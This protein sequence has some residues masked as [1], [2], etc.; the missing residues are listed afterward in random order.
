LRLVFFC[1]YP[2]QTGYISVQN[3][4]IIKKNS[5][6][7]NKKPREGKKVK[8]VFANTTA[9]RE[10]KLNPH[11]NTPAAIKMNEINPKDENTRK[12]HRQGKLICPPDSSSRGHKNRTFLKTTNKM[13][14][15]FRQCSK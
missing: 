8:Y 10:E 9:Q 4:Q 15:L 14:Y 11:A 2:S 1:K 7:K 13:H 12:I 6:T 3:D 5:G